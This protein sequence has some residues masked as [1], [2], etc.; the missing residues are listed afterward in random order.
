VASEACGMPVVNSRDV[1]QEFGKD[2]GEGFARYSRIGDRAKFGSILV[3]CGH[4]A[5]CLRIMNAAL[6]AT[7]S[8][9]TGR[10]K[11]FTDAAAR[12]SVWPSRQQKRVAR[13]PLSRNADD[14]VAVALA[15]RGPGAS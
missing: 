14:H 10:L 4:Y 6:C 1:A 3:S 12:R 8:P 2:H 9:A 15:R 11:L 5:R 7:P 13:K